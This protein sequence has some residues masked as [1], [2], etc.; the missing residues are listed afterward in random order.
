MIELVYIL[1]I[2]LAV[3]GISKS[4]VLR[5]TAEA[6][7]IRR[8][9]V[10]IVLTTIA[11]LSPNFWFYA[12]IAA[13]ILVWA[14]RKDANPVALFL[15]LL[16]VLPPVPIE[17]SV[18]GD[19]ELFSL[20]HYRMLSF[21]ILIPAAFKIRRS[22]KRNLARVRRSTDY[23]LLACGAVEV[24]LFVPPDAPGHFI[25]QDSVTNF[26]RR[27]FLYFIDVLIVYYVV[28]R[29]SED[30]RRIR[31]SQAAFCM[32]AALM[33]FVA[34]FEHFRGWLLYQ[35]LALRWS[36]MDANY[37]LAMLL[38]DSWVR[39]QASSG[40]PLV[41]GIML[42][43]A[44]GFWM[45][46][47]SWASTARLRWAPALVFLSGLVAT[48]SRGAW[49]GALAIYL[50]YSALRPGG[51]SRIFKAALSIF[52]AAILFSFSSTGERLLNSLP[53]LSKTGSSDS[54]V[55]YRQ[56]LLDR[57][58]EL[59]KSHP[60][61][62]DQ[63]AMADMQDLRQGQGIIDVVNTFAGKALFNGLVGLG[64]FLGFIY[65]GLK[66]A[67]AAS[68]AISPIDQELA[69]LGINLVACILGMT[70]MLADCSLIYGIPIMLYV[71]IA[72]ATGYARCVASLCGER[73]SLL[74]A[75][76]S[77]ST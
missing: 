8:R 20:D 67:Y 24:A 10:W 56:R 65:S 42:A 48:F 21:F 34:I 70:V 6:D 13:P 46:L 31:D 43:I 52:M 60:F 14:G 28:S 66:G 19:H 26:L 51:L 75:A 12:L 15:F 18:I 59:V 71:L 74:D 4:L 68:K 55:I 17:I 41:L 73:N 77:R 69:L 36:P 11:F 35:A 25:F 2:A 16:F 33:A 44:V 22:T 53:Y 23:L 30:S 40:H 37:N 5:F 58:V 1:A 32:A 7:F 39:S 62:G 64:L 54:S 29:S 76:G 9:N 61:F 50:A 45:Y 72:L 63:N 27:V 57:T 38:R 3:F 47:Q 49:V